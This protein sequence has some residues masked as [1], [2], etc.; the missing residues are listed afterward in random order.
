[1][2][3]RH[4]SKEKE[5][6][7]MKIHTFEGE[8]NIGYRLLRGYNISM[9]EEPVSNSK[10]PNSLTGGI[11]TS[12]DERNENG[13]GSKRL[14]YDGEKRYLGVRVKMPVRDILRNIRIANG[15]NPKDIQGSC[16]KSSK[17][18]KKRVNTKGDRRCN[19]R[20]HPT[21]SLEELAIIVE[22]LEE[23]LKDNKPYSPCNKS[24]SSKYCPKPN[25]Q[26]WHTPEPLQQSYPMNLGQEKKI[27]QQAPNYCMPELN[28]SHSPSK[29]NTTV[30]PLNSQV[31]YVGDESDNVIPSPDS[32][33]SYSP[34]STSDYQMPSTQDSVFTLPQSCSYEL[35][36]DGACD[37][38]GSYSPQAQNSFRQQCP[39]NMGQDWNSTAHFWTQLQR[40]ESLLMGVSDTE[41]LATDKN[42]RTAL[43]KV[44]FQGNRTLGYAIAK[45][46][47]ALHSLDVKDSEGK[48]ALHLAAQK[49]QHHMVVDLIHLGASV[50]EKDRSGKTCLHLSAENGYIQVL[51]VL[52]N[53]MKEGIYVDVKATDNSGLSVLQCATVALNVT[54]QELERSVDPSRI[55]FLTLCKEQMMET[56]D[57]LLQMGSYHPTLDNH[58][59]E[60]AYNIGSNRDSYKCIQGVFSRSIKVNYVT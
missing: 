15:M 10:G 46:M 19:K 8:Q 12:L 42:G 27:P 34:S 44:V 58:S 4:K 18:E 37:Y 26:S 13:K 2:R 22:V 17:D 25:E 30:P 49:N 33:M 20:K 36:Q 40:E 6:K 53:L 52:N 60:N 48:T 38:Q 32:Y 1:M 28:L 24:D 23:D 55:R 39:S 21:K 45:R 47:A 5:D 50:N 11:Q 16:G 41:F 51:E 14:S 7:C 43:H 54:M 56:L 57:C 35:D 9:P 31:Q 29:Q 59:G 3:S